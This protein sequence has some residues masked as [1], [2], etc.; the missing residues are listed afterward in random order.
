[1]L[2]NRLENLIK[3]SINDFCNKTSDKK[4]FYIEL[5]NT[6]DNNLGACSHPGKIAHKNAA[7]ILINKIKQLM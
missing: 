3:Q 6:S 4:I 5:Q 2:G 1:M 7:Q